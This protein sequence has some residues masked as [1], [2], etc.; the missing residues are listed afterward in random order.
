MKKTKRNYVVI[1]LVIILLTLAFV[2]G[3]YMPMY[4]N[5]LIARFFNA[6]DW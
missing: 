1:A 6:F 2:L 3:I 5:N 4:I